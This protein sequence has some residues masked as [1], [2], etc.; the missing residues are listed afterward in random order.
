MNLRV[1][2]QPLLLAT[3][4]VALGC[5]GFAPPAASQEAIPATTRKIVL[6]KAEGAG[7][8]WNLVEAP[9]PAPGPDQVLV[10]V[11]ALSLNRGDVETL[12]PE[13]GKPGLVAGSDAAGDVLAVGSAVRD[14][15][16]G[17]RVTSLYFE[18]WTDGPP[19]Q[20]KLART[21][22]ASVDGV[23]G[24]YMVLKS[25]GIVKAPKGLSYEEAA[26]LP[27]AGLTAWMAVNGYRELRAGDVVVVQGT[28]GVSVFALQFARALGARVIATSSSD[29][30]LQQA[31]TLGAQDGINYRT[32]PSWSKRVLELT[33][34]RGADVV[35]DVGGKASLPESVKSLAY[36]GTI[37]IVGGLSGYDGAVPAAGLL[38][39]TARA[40]GIYVGSRADYERMR[41]VIEQRGLR[42]AI[43]RVFELK[44]YQAALDHMKS[45]AFVGK[46]VIKL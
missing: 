14:F 2:S 7:F 37:S 46:I 35:V 8:R 30:K 41:A 11:R 3:L 6:E 20:E 13:Y 26:T 31:K 38:L 23:F 44:D 45:G 33:D 16:A 12:D 32:S 42:P 25:T 43:D 39:K 4:A 9:V 36:R 17:D 10:R 18:N 5:Q 21:F 40:Q 22:G 29:D 1:T 15:R 27:T 28:G 24:E 34:G 19:S